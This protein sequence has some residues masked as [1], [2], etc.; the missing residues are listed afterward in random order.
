MLLPFLK[1]ILFK[2]Q[3]GF[4]PKHSTIHP[5]IQFQNY[6]AESNN[7]PRLEISLANF[8]DLSKAFDVINHEILLNK[9]NTYGI[10]GNANNWFKSYLANRSQFVDIDGH[11]SSL[12]N[13]ECGVPSMLYSWSFVLSHLCE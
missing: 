10:R 8:C 11:S 12:L 5:I 1:P 2:H 9:L 13:I 6:C 7:K 3:Y 4:R